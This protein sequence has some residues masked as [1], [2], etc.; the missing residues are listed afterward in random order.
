MRLQKNPKWKPKYPSGP[1]VAVAPAVPY[2]FLDI[3]TKMG[4]YRLIDQESDPTM[5]LEQL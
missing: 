1:K 4:S 3:G 2:K 5:L